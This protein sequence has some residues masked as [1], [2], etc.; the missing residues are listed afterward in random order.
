MRR[1]VRFVSLLAL[2]LA[3]ARPAF[4]QGG[5]VTIFGGYAFPTYSHTFTSSLPSV[6][7]LPG[8]EI[9]PDGNFV[10][11]AT[12][13]S[14]FG[15]AAAFELGGFFAIEGRFDSTSIKLRSSGVRYT[16]SGGGLEGSISLAAGDIPVDR[17]NMLSLN[18]RLRTPGLVSFYA[19]G[20]LSYL[21]SFSVGG[22]I[23]LVVDVSGLPLPGFEIPVSL[24][25]APSESS[26]RF[27]VNG[28]AGLR[29]AV[30]P[31]VS[32]VVE[33]R[34]FYFKDYE[35]AINVPDLPG[36]ANSGAIRIVTFEPVVVNVV[37]GLAIRF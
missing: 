15:G 5:D 33:G 26:Y 32:L 16:I 37:G 35:L 11:E 31:K 25:V 2:V 12:G 19:S 8:I 29:F 27:G 34:V 1:I 6:P 17:L 9:T 23:P 10:L 20:G 21:P 36:F 13:G 14:V 28:G 3:G 22:S 4:A 18:I 7:A 24:D 30:A